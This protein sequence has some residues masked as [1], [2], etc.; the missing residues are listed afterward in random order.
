MLITDPISFTGI[1][2]FSYHGV[3]DSEVLDPTYVEYEDG[4]DNWVELASFDGIHDTI[5]VHTLT[6]GVEITRLR[7]RFVSDIAWS[8]E[9]GLRNSD[10]AAIID[11]I[12]VSDDTGLIDYEDFESWPVGATDNPGSIWHAGVKEGFGM[13]SGLVSGLFIDED[14]CNLNLSTQIVFFTDPKDPYI[15]PYPDTPFCEGAGGIEEP[16]QEERV[17]SLP[18]DMTKYST[19]N[20]EV[21]DADIPADDLS[22][23]GGALFRY[24]V[25]LDLP[26]R[27]LVF[28]TWSIRNLDESGCPTEWMERYFV[29]CGAERNYVFSTNDIGDLVGNNQIQVSFIIR[30]MCHIWYS[31]MGDCAEHTTSPW[32]DNVRIQRYE[33]TGPQWSYRDLDLFQDNFPEEEFDLTSWVRADAAND[34]APP[35]APYIQ[36]GDS[37]TVTCN[38]PLGGGI[39]E[40]AGGPKVYLHVRCTDLSHAGR[41]NIFGPSLEGTYG[42]YVSDDGSEWTILQ[43]DTAYAYAGD[44]VEDTY[45]VDINDS[46]LTRGYI[47]EYYFSAQDNA[48]EVSTLPLGGGG[49]GAGTGITSGPEKM[50]EFTCL[51]TGSSQVLYVDDFHGRGTFEGM[52]QNYFDPT[53]EAV[54]PVTNQP[55]RYDVNSPSSLVSN[56]PGSRAKNYHLT[57]YNSIIWDSGDL[58]VGTITDGTPNSDKSDDCT[59]LLNWMNNT[60]HQSGLFVCGDNIAYDLEQNLISPQAQELLH[61]WCGVSHVNESYFELTGGLETG[62]IPNPLITGVEGGIFYHGGNTYQFCISGGCPVVNSFDVLAPIENGVPALAYP[63]Y[64]G[65]TYYA[66]IQSSH[67]NAMGSMVNTMWFGFSFMYIRDTG[68]GAPMMRNRIF[69]DIKFWI[70][71]G[72]GNPDVT[73]GEVP[74]AYRLA[75]NFPNPFN[76][77]TTIKFDMK[78]KGHVSL[79][80]Y[81]VA[82]QLVRTLVDEVKDAGSCSVIWDGTNNGGA[83]V[84]SG[85]YFYRM[86]TKEFCKTK[87]IVLLR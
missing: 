9:D 27:N 11:S 84:A 34:I 41:P 33:T 16:C 10:G 52:V 56:G 58:N 85:I 70:N 78:T 26:L 21:Q 80:V 53:F 64:A 45:M 50:F 83:K 67:T 19:N 15:G 77:T 13:H 48:G 20:D 4:E 72:I 35:T 73:G 47:V 30:D 6:T 74:A 60:D 86:E 23:L 49:F 69:R 31:T 59:M 37:I 63:E 36:P 8:D 22:K 79:K 75:Q 42:H 1:L 57:W 17:I 25:Y 5:A 7:F 61:T 12:V 32:F 54:I 62:G 44:P 81:N 24:T 29:I 82:G 51:P 39:A 18:I 87:K 71:M 3:F 55:D 68:P 66:G 76:P 38:S 40:D 2:V 43:C 14:P 65:E 28:Y 46:L